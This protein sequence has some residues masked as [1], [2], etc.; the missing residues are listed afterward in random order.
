MT[1]Y[2]HFRLIK[3]GQLYQITNVKAVD[4][5]LEMYWHGRIM[6]N[7]HDSVRS[8]SVTIQTIADY[9]RSHVKLI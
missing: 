3:P 2:D 9:L 6:V 4:Y 5:Y 1:I 8:Q 7:D